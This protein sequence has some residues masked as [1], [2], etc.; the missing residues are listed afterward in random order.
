MLPKMLL[1]IWSK[2]Y[3]DIILEMPAH[4]EEP[5]CSISTSQI[6]LLQQA[7][8]HWGI[9]AAKTRHFAR[10]CGSH[11]PDLRDPVLTE[12]GHI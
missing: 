4:T 3:Y 2:S 5:L 1:P 6:K 11:G 12:T 10:S 8:F 7:L 9:P